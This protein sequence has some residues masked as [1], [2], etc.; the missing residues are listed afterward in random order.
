MILIYIYYEIFRDLS[1]S[2]LLIII[3]IRFYLLISIEVLINLRLYFFINS[4]TSIKS[5]I[6]YWILY[7]L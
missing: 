1:L 5:F 7:L 3:I 4:L 2:R 6:E